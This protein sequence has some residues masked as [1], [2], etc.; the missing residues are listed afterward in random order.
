MRLYT[1]G[2]LHLSLGNSKP[3][4]IFGD[5][6]TDHTKKLFDNFSILQPDDL[7]VICGDLSWGMHI[8]DCIEDFKFIDSL[9]GK[10]IILKGNHDYWWNTMN[11][12]LSV[13]ENNSISSINILNN[14]SF[15]FKNYSICGT[16]GWFCEEESGTSH[17][18]KI[19]NREILRLENS[20]KSAKNSKIIV[21]LH[22]P[23]VYH[24]YKCN[25]I[26]E[27]L[28][29]YEVRLCCY[30]HIHGKG[31]KSAINGWFEGVEYKLV[32]ADALNFKPLELI[33]I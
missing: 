31:I 13:F 30:G 9:P 17:D 6:W 18:K 1:I 29:Y 20:L 23:P 11:K 4:D 3:M 8:E 5:S 7:T 32:S 21:F 15:E 10:K 33:D 26:I 14:N 12:T 22:Y 2:D 25:E 28:K 19:M 24:D 16:R 27:L